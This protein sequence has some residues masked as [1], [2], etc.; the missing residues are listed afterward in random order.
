MSNIWLN[1]R[2]CLVFVVA[3]VAAYVTGFFVTR[4]VISFLK[5]NH[6]VPVTNDV[7]PDCLT[8]CGSLPVPYPFGIGPGCSY[9]PSFSLECDSS[10]DP[11][12]TFTQKLDSS[13]TR[14]RVFNVTETQI[15]VNGLIAYD[16]PPSNGTSATAISSKNTEFLP[17]PNSPFTLSKTANT[18]WVAGSCDYIAPISVP[19][20]GNKSLTCPVSCRGRTTDDKFV[21]GPCDTPNRCC[22]TPNRCCARADVES[23]ETGFS[24]KVRLKDGKVEKP[25]TTCGYVAFG[26]KT[27][28][29]LRNVSDYSDPI[30]FVDRTTYSVPMA[31]DW[32]IGNQTCGEARSSY[33]C[34]QNSD[35]EN[36]DTRGY[37]CS[38]TQGYE[39]NPYNFIGCRDK[40][41]C[42]KVGEEYP[43]SAKAKCNNRQGDYKCSCRLGY[44]GDGL[45]QGKGCEQLSVVELTV[46]SI[47]GLLC[48]IVFGSAINSLIRK[49][50]LA[51]TRRKFFEENGGLILMEKLSCSS[52]GR[53]YSSFKLF[54]F[55]E[56]KKSTKNFSKDLIV[57]VGGFGTVYKGTLRD[58]TLVAVKMSKSMDITQIEQFINEMV[59]L[60]QIHHRNVVRLLGC[61]LEAEIPILVYEFVENGALQDHI[62]KGSNWLTWDNRLRI[63]TETATALGYLH[64]A[65]SASIIHRDIKSA[66][67]LLDQ[68][69]GAKISDFGTSRLRPLDQTHM[70]TL[71][72]GTFGYMDPEYFVSSQLT[73]KSDVY[74]FGVVVAEL[75]TGEKPLSPDRKMEYRNLGIYFTTA[76]KEG[77][78]LDVIDPLIVDEAPQEHLTCVA[79]IV[80]EC[81]SM[82]GINRPTMKDV[83]SRLAALQRQTIETSDDP[84]TDDNKVSEA[85]YG[86][87]TSTADYSFTIDGR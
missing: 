67:I 20:N 47:L 81:L 6:N 62:H 5:A 57:G 23:F 56:L 44:R 69:Y 78:L 72:Q 33:A 26:M 49:R 39:G 45:K 27:R 28:F 61:C 37:R 66:N 41:E 87:H 68:N 70:S 80:Q 11:A 8:Q 24:M 51:K 71:V 79:E 32:V 76:F 22:D 38:C 17:H 13:S 64:S 34:Q 75:L 1:A 18:F 19:G 2:L 84:S 43:C 77:R 36:V 86:R 31:F 60:T 29:I 25:H 7:N 83:A 42:A 46:G 9:S 12:Q 50:I 85:W 4:A 35:C 73:D 74:S 53:S 82:K 16:C 65:A 52:R 15:L 63:A 14:F 21:P 58:G 40:N 55:D 3:F 48:I 54:K 30:E 59:I 10:F